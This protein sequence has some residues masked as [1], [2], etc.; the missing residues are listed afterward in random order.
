MFNI[1][2]TII[3]L[4][5]YKLMLCHFEVLG[6]GNNLNRG[7]NMGLNNACLSIVMRYHLEI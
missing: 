1:V 6:A 5:K 4:S 2:I 7:K 3:Y